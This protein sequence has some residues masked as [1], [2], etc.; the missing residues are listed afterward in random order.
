MINLRLV[1]PT[2]AAMC[3]PARSCHGG[4]SQ[5][6]TLFI[7]EAFVDPTGSCKVSVE[8]ESQMLGNCIAE[9]DVPFI[10]CIVRLYAASVN[11]TYVKASHAR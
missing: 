4:T 10:E 2:F 3:I 5:G 7:T 8:S 9:R 11:V 6:A 1:S